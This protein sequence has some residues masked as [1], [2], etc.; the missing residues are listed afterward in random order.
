MFK[1]LVESSCGRSSRS[2]TSLVVSFGFHAVFVVILLLIPLLH[3]QTFPAQILTYLPDYP[4]PDPPP[5]PPPPPPTQPA[6]TVSPP[7][8]LRL[9]E[10]HFVAPEVIPE[11]LPPPMD[12][13]PDVTSFTSN[14]QG[15]PGGFS[16]GQ[17]GEVNGWVAGIVGN[18]PT[19]DP[20]PPPPPAQMKQ[21]VRQGGEVFA[22]KLIRRVAPV[23]PELARRARIQGRVLLQ[24]NVDETGNVTEVRIVSG[25]PLLVKAAEEAVKQ[26]KYSP[27]LLNGEP[28]PV[29][30]TV[31]VNFV[32]Q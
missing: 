17:P 28:V 20:P 23:Y 6:E 31:T 24:V 5:P 3:Y 32:L 19:A 18:L 27:T 25:K 4:P 7:Q 26:W 10:S 14:V 8:E 9:P 2:K 13:I 15:V 22:S 1:D 11:T 21:P 16:G 12:D 30:A 29:I